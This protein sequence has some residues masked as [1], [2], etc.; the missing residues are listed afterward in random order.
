MANRRNI[1][2]TYT[3][4]NKHTILDCN[5]I[6]DPTNG[7][8]LGIRSL[9]DGGRIGAVYMKTSASPAANN[10]MTSASTGLILVQL[11]DNYISYLAGNSGQVAALSGSSISSGLTVGVAYVIVSLGASTLDQWQAAGVGATITPAVGVSFVAKATSV[12]GGGAVQA[13][14][15]GGSGIDHIEVIGDANLMNNTVTGA[16][17]GQAVGQT[18]LLACYAGGVLT[19]PNPGSV[20]SLQFF[21]NDSKSGV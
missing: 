3:P 14:H 19:D 7:N 17:V 8:G 10:P 4:H 9:K 12:S 2:F 5:F 13:L 15:A 6:V 18:I 21:M 1:Q 16:V 20:I 11:Q